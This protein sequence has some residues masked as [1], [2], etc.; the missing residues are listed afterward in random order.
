LGITARQYG[1][2][3]PPDGGRHSTGQGPGTLAPPGGGP[4]RLL[5][6]HGARREWR[7][8][9]HPGTK[10]IEHNVCR[11]TSLIGAGSLSPVTKLVAGTGPP[12]G[13][14]VRLLADR[15]TK[16]IE[17]RKLSSDTGI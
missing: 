4:V 17:A 13:G 10:F 3:V 9:C 16:L 1:E 14:R 7:T 6:D 15:G 12:A 8:F 5:A 11:G 2:V